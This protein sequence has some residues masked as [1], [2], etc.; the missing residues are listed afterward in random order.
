MA[1]D[2]HN[3]IREK[4]GGSPLF[5]LEKED[6]IPMKIAVS[7][8]KPS[9]D[10]P[11]DPRFG[12]CSCFLIVETEDLDFEAVE[13]SNMASPSGAGIQSAQL[14]ADKG[15]KYV[16]TGNCGP[17]AHQTLSAAGID[18]VAGVSGTVRDAVSNFK[19]GKYETAKGPNVAGHFGTGVGMP[20]G[21]NPPAS[22]R[23]GMGGG[24][25]MGRGMGGGR[26]RGMGMGR[27]MGVGRGMRDAG[28]P[29]SFSDTPKA[30][31]DEKTLLKEE[32][33]ALARRL[34]EIQGRFRQMEGTGSA[35]TAAV[36]D[37]ELCT[38][39]GACME[40][41]PNNAIGMRKGIAVVVPG[42][43][44][45]CGSCVDVC[46]EDAISLP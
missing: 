25:G 14:M 12:R 33:E 27:G 3:Q 2:E 26:G 32:A 21:A 19:R 36:V 37:T 30:Q 17:N 9:L 28:L 38:G 16:L 39:C 1:R 4:T 23:G 35:G 7:A 8:Q 10:S 31:K 45:M 22:V 5:D 46:P 41:C 42:D 34:D 44:I 29:Q 18:I 15:V 43:C 40:V 6:F 13:N 20:E 24:M 11:V